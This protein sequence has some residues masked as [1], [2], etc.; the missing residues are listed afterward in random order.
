MCACIYTYFFF[1]Y[2]WEHRTGKMC[3]FSSLHIYIHIYIYIYIYNVCVRMDL[4]KAH[5]ENDG[6]A[7]WGSVR[8]VLYD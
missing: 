7:M 8:D 3:P 4:E 6:D 1:F 5:D 2:E